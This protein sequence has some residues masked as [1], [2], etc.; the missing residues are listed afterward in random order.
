MIHRRRDRVRQAA[1]ERALAELDGTV[2]Q[3]TH[4]QQTGA[5]PQGPGTDREFEPE[6]AAMRRL[7]HLLE[8]VPAEAWAAIPAEE[9]Q[10]SRGRTW[11][12]ALRP[13]SMSR[14]LAATAAVALLALG[15]AGGAVVESGG[16]SSHPAAQA[17]HGPAVVLRPLATS[18][19]GSLA[20]AYMPAPGQ[21]LLRVAYLPPS[22]PSTY[23]ELWL[24]TDLRHLAP[25]AAF[26]VGSDGRAQLDLRLPDNP[27]HYEY[28]DISVQQ[29]GAGTAH[30]A[31]SVLRGRLA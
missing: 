31:D 27:S 6:L 19:A 14:A 28:L 9:A 24:M 8:Q 20:V 3:A 5:T 11:R 13:I 15:F 23:Y 17:A 26:R 29:L 12:R 2:P 7:T 30:S 1:A 25:V 10:D 4:A 21:V 16:S 18:T 22:P